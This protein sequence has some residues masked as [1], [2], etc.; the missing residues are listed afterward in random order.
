MKIHIVQKGDTL[1]KIAKKY[2]V[3]YDALKKL[4][5][6]L[7]DPEKIVQGMKI[8]IPSES[9]PVKKA[10]Q[11]VRTEK[12]KYPA[13]HP[14]KDVSPKP[15]PVMKED[16]GKEEPLK[17]KTMKPFEKKPEMPAEHELPQMPPF[18]MPDME[19]SVESHEESKEKPMMPPPQFQIPMP[20]YSWHQPCMSYQQPQLGYYPH[21]HH[22]FH[23]AYQPAAYPQMTS[24]HQAPMSPYM[25]DYEQGSMHG[26]SQYESPFDESSD[27]DVPGPYPGGQEWTPYSKPAPM[28]M[29]SY[30]SFP[31]AGSQGYGPGGQPG[32]YTYPQSSPPVYYGGTY[33]T[34]GAYSPTAPYGIPGHTGTTGWQGIP[35]MPG[36]YGS[37]GGGMPRRYDG[38]NKKTHQ[39]YSESDQWNAP[40]NKGRDKE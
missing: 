23:H 12:T 25:Y 10:K 6:H 9:K 4:N 37:D 31:D 33:G 38:L 7:S 26:N 20:S 15:I 29:Q 32:G 17:E 34:P 22:S 28:G 13:E 19:E 16:D 14:Y 40:W 24:Y 8:K 27:F 18:P 11:E 39:G 1:W 5:T 36:A 2:N 3:E 21:M 30:G 35:Y